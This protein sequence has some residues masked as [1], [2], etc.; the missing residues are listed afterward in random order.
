[1][2]SPIAGPSNY[3]EK[4]DISMFESS[5]PQYSE[6][7]FQCSQ[8]IDASESNLSF[9]NSAVYNESLFEYSEQMDQDLQVPT[10]SSFGTQSLTPV[11]TQSSFGTLKDLGLSVFM[12][13]FLSKGVRAFTTKEAN[14]SR[15]VTLVRWTVEAVNGRIKN[16]FKFFE[17][18]IPG[19]Y[20]GHISRFFRICCS[21]INKYFVPLFQ[22]KTRHD[23]I[24]RA[25]LDRVDMPN[26]LQSRVQELGL[27]RMTAKW[28]KADED[29][30]PDFPK[31]TWDNLLA[32]TLGSYQ[33]RIAASYTKQ[34]AGKEAKYSLYL[35]TNILKIVRAKMHSRFSS[36]NHHYVW[37]EYGD[38]EGLSGI[39][40]WYCTCMAGARNLGTCSHVASVIRYLGYDRYQLVQVQRKRRPHGIIDAR[41]ELAK[42]LA[43]AQLEESEVDEDEE[44]VGQEETDDEELLS[45]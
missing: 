12:P 17:T 44:L 40:G 41:S 29:S 1:M 27:E 23:I 34:H 14:E 13:K 11:P 45:L 42:A 24:A 38:E 4:A 33:L 22:E 18:V 15:R 9:N 32:L 21:I 19:S 36:N 3:S 5:V 10:Q 35:H 43:T 6:P 37:V 26:L 28:K 7:I 30:V 20:K 25:V 31:L 16:A 39:L 8:A 2:L